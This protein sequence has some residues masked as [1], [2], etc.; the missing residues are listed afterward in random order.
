MFNRLDVNVHYDNKGF[1]IVLNPSTGTKNNHHNDGIE[2][3]HDN[4]RDEEIKNGVESSNDGIEKQSVN[5]IDSS[6]S[7]THCVVSF[8][9]ALS[10]HPLVLSVEIEGPIITSDY[11]SQWITQ[12]KT[13]GKRPLRDLGIDGANQIISII[14]SGLDINHHYF[15]PTDSKV[16]DVRNNKQIE[17]ECRMIG[18]F[19]TFSFF[20]I[21]IGMGSYST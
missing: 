17:Y 9:M 7:N 15:G 11:E 18:I 16:F 20:S 10:T 5:R 4:D 6:A 2:Y 13:T 14:D 12:S 3:K 19:L 1:D 8:I 21:H